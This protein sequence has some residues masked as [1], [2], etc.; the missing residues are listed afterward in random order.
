MLHSKSAL[1]SFMEPTWNHSNMLEQSA[2][3]QERNATAPSPVK[4]K[5]GQFHPIWDFDHV[6]SR[7]WLRFLLEIILE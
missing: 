4:A 2:F 7:I 6:P 1:T 5:Q 3:G